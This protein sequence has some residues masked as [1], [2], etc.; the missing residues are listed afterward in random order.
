MIWDGVSMVSSATSG[1]G[2][3]YKHTYH[4]TASP[5]L[6]VEVD[7][8]GQVIAAD[9]AGAGPLVFDRLETRIVVRFDYD[10]GLSDAHAILR[11]TRNS[12]K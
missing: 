3:S 7:R 4:Y 2:S 11:L 9:V 5:T 1:A 6:L 10:A 8:A 12:Y